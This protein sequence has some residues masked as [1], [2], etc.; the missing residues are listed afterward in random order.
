M[1][2]SIQPQTMNPLKEVSSTQPPIN[3]RCLLMQKDET[4]LLPLWIRYHGELFG[5]KNLFIYD[6][7]SA[8]TTQSI[9]RAAQRDLGVN[10]DYRR[11]KPKDFERKGAIFAKQMSRWTAENVADFYFP[12]DCDE[13]VGA[14]SEEGYS[15]SPA[16]IHKELQV[17]KQMPDTA[18]RVS[19][20]LDNSLFDE[21]TF[22]KIPRKPK[23]FFSN[24]AIS[25]LDV[26]FHHCKEP[27]KEIRTNIVYF[28]FHNRPFKELVQFSK[29]KLLLR[30]GSR[31]IADRDTLSAYRGKGRHL[32]R[33]LTSSAEEYALWLSSHPSV[34]TTSLRHR[35]LELGVRSPWFRNCAE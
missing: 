5:Y 18:F 26:G 28:H 6:N 8:D 33:C 2:F 32:V 20:R 23:L 15:C 19:E 12:L 17:T 14:R 27:C 9:L 34:V 30:V 29:Q 13:F 35:F 24:T 25:G 11:A 22:Y 3:V 31:K 4:E 21:T 1:C 10:V 7:G 16:S